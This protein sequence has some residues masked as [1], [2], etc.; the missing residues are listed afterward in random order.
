MGAVRKADFY[1]GSMLSC[2]IN[3]GLAP[4]IIEPGDSRRIYK[5]TTDSGDYQLYAKYV[6]S[7]LRRQ[8]K[9][10]Q[11]WQ[12]NF[13]P[14]E[15]KY[16][17]NYKENGLKLYFI[18]I[19]GQKKLQNSE[20]AILSLEEAKDCLDVD[21]ERERYRITIKWEKGIHG[22][23]AYGTGR[24]DILNGRDN[25]IRISRDISSYF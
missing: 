21:Y 23:K 15:V 8:K 24:A 17:R 25:T 20:I 6:S 13:N 18:L 4:A 2:F 5:L 14:E 16:I 1:Y 11:L 7:P 19:C 10:A 22:L 9:D 12:F 3:N